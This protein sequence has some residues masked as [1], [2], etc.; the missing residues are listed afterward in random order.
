MIRGY[1]GEVQRKGS[2][3]II[4]HLQD[5]ENTVKPSP[6]MS[7]PFFNIMPYIV[8]GMEGK[9]LYPTRDC[10][11]KKVLFS[12]PKLKPS[13]PLRSSRDMTQLKSPTIRIRTD[14]GMRDNNLV[15]RSYL[16]WRE[17]ST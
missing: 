4:E 7:S 14:D 10:K 8:H 15:Q 5:H 11:V 6:S 1:M 13:L 9:D 2:Q 16:P 12:L 3:K 17:L